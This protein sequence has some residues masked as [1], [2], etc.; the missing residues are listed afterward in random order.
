VLDEVLLFA[1]A[2]GHLNAK[3]MPLKAHENILIFYRKLP[4]YNPQKNT[5]TAMIIWFVCL[6]DGV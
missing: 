6:F 2:T 5:I 3:K 4:V 1:S